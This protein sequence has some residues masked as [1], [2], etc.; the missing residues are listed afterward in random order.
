MNYEKYVDKLANINVL[1]RLAKNPSLLEEV[2]KYKINL[3]DFVDRLHKICFVSIN[4]LYANGLKEIEVID[5][6]NYIKQS[7]P[8]EE[9]YFLSKDGQD[10]LKK[11]I[12]VSKEEKFDYYYIRMKKFSLLRAYMKCG[13]DIQDFY[14]PDLI[15]FE[16]RSK[17]ENWLDN[18][19]IE[20]IVNAIDKK[21][22]KIEEEPSFELPFP[23][24]I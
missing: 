23:F 6:Y 12:F 22:D 14:D 16:K 18:S 8:Q 11:A 2:D 10:F 21:I 19:S 5:V 24:G 1:G 15:D 20:E 3:S 7:L 17:Q 9:K 13:V 4:N